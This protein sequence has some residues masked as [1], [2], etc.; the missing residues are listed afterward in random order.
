M[1][2]SLYAHDINK[3][4]LLVFFS[5]VKFDDYHRHIFS[6]F[7]F[8]IKGYDFRILTLLSTRG[9]G[10]SYNQCTGLSSSIFVRSIQKHRI[11]PDITILIEIHSI[12]I[13]GTS[14]PTFP[15]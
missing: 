15:S 5:L 7:P 1:Y 13:A 2:F 10:M 6:F 14:L 12:K 9:E 3:E 4:G 11:S 8:L